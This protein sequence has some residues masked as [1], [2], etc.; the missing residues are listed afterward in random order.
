MGELGTRIKKLLDALEINQTKFSEVVG[1]SKNATT[2]IIKNRA[3]PRSDIIGRFLSSYPKVN[4]NWMMTGNGAMFNQKGDF[5]SLKE[6]MTDSDL[7]EV[8]IVPSSERSAYTKLFWEPEYLHKLS[9]E[10]RHISKLGDYRRFE[11]YDD[12]MDDHDSIFPEGCTVLCRRL[13]KHM[14][15]KLQRGDVFV[16]VGNEFNYKIRQ[17]KEQ[18]DEAIIL[19]SFNSYF[20][21]TVIQP[22]NIAEIWV[23][24]DRCLPKGRFGHK[25]K[26]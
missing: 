13:E 24:M 3:V 6:L 14:W 17:L 25:L 26:L 20:D 5:E 19:S 12:S 23:Y 9:V 10:Y 18:S 2:S 15:S 22:Q 8:R 16:F 4:A 21:D 1:I 7:R 11:M